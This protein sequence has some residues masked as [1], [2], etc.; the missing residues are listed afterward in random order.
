MNTSRNLGYAAIAVFVLSFFLPAY[1]NE[2]GFA[3]FGLC[4]Y[5]LLG[6]DLAGDHVLSGI[7]LYY[8]GFAICN[9]LF[10]GLAA[11]F[12]VRKHRRKIAT[13]I[14]VIISLHV[15]SFLLLTIISGKSMQIAEF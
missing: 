2:S 7:W 1:G 8:G 13:V 4:W 15:L 3:C 6:R 11:A 10:I 5:I 12:I 9:L 14:S